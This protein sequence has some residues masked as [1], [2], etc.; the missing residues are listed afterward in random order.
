MPITALQQHYINEIRAFQPAYEEADNFFHGHV[1]ELYASDRVRRLLMKSGLNDLDAINF[2]KIPCLALASRLEVTGVQAKGEDGTDLS[3][4]LSAQWERNMMGWFTPDTHLKTSYLGDYYLFVWPVLG[5]TEEGVDGVDAP[6][7]AVDIR[8]NSPLTT[9]V[10]YDPEDPLL[11]VAAVKVWTFEAEDGSQRSRAN[12]YYPNRI[13]K[14]VTTAESDGSGT[15]PEDWTEAVDPD[16]GD[17]ESWIIPNPYGEVPIF[18]HR[19]DFPYGTPDNKDAYM[20]QIMINKLVSAHASV[21]DFQSFPQ[22]YLLTD[23]VDDNTFGGSD[24]D[25][26]FPDDDENDPES[27]FN[28]SRFHADPGSVWVSTARSAGQFQS[29]TPD[30][31]IAP[32]NRYVLAMS[33]VTQT[34]MHEFD[35][36]GQ[37]PSGESLKVADAPLVNRANARKLLEGAAW[38]DMYIFVLEL[39]GHPGAIVTVN[40]KS[41]ATNPGTE[42]WDLAAKKIDMGVSR[43]TVLIELG[44]KPED[45]AGWNVDKWTWLNPQKGTPLIVDLV[46]A[47]VVT[48]G[49][50]LEKVLRKDWELPPHPEGAPFGKADPSDLDYGVIMPDERRVG[51]GLPPLPDGQGKERATAAGSASAP[52]GAQPG[53]PTLGLPG[54]SQ[55]DMMTGAEGEPGGDYLSRLADQAQAALDS[56]ALQ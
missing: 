7:V 45:I 56:G 43:Q 39:L 16:S 46:N 55:P 10:F 35:P 13:E 4:L 32:F 51:L 6:V 33:Q 23:P 36:G 54:Q 38:Q 41:S 44:Y 15:S 21:I 11:K 19:T 30:T 42:D 18:H 12:F 37:P 1:E 53:A 31:F 20:P 25:A 14:W 22:R 29:A 9:R 17:A 49:P 52:G 28:T 26:D 24:S 3:G 48:P 27:P 34:P 8:V 50:E 47:G 5:E 2:A 40:W